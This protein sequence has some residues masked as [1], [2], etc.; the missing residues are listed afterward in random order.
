MHAPAAIIRTRPITNIPDRASSRNIA[1]NIAA[2]TGSSMLR[3]EEAGAPS[4]LVPREKKQAGNADDSV[5][6]PSIGRIADEVI[7]GCTLT[8]AHITAAARKNSPEDSDR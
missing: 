4:F 6:I 8:E 2:V 7:G 3:I 5:I 1:P